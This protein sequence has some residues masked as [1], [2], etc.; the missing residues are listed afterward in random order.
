MK[1]KLKIKEKFQ[2]KMDNFM[3]KGGLSIF[4]SLLFLFCIMYFMMLTIRWSATYFVP[5]EVLSDINEQIWRVFLMMTDPGALENEDDSVLLQ[6]ILG[7]VTVFVGMVFFSSLVA[8]ITTE[9]N[10]RIAMLR[11]GKSQVLE[12]GHTIILGFNNR[13]LEIVKELTLAN[14]DE[15]GL[16]IVILAEK[17][18]EEM[19]DF[20]RDNVSDLKSS[21]IVTRNGNT[22]S[23]LALRKMGVKQCKS[24]IVLNQAKPSDP[25]K[26]QLIGDARVLKSILS[27]ATVVGEE[28]S[29]MVVCEFFSDKNRDLGLG[30]IPGKVIALQ[31][32]YIMAK[33]LVQTSR[34]PGLAFVYSDLVGYEG[35]E[36]YFIPVPPKALGRTYSEIIWHYK[37]TM[38]LGVMLENGQNLWNPPLEYVLKENDQLIVI[39]ESRSAIHYHDKPVV[40][41]REFEYSGSVVREKVD[42]ELIVGWSRKVQRLIDEYATY[43]IDG[44]RIDVIV[45]HATDSMNRQIQQIRKR[46]PYLSITLFEDDIHEKGVLEKYRPEN[47]DNVILVTEETDDDTE[48]MDAGTI[49]SLLELR[50]YFRDFEKRLNTKIHTQLITE[51]MD[52]RNA[53]LIY[54]SGVR[55]FFIPDQF[56][57]KILTQ[58]SQDYRINQAY[59]ELFSAEGNEIYIKPISLYFK[60]FPVKYRFAECIAAAQKRNE[61]CLGVR[62]SAHMFSH[63]RHFGI[64]LVPDKDQEFY[65]VRD[66]K[67]IVLA[68]NTT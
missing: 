51:V 22:S 45:S 46:Y 57:S 15:K 67:M 42:S 66:D 1:E 54:G 7:A 53:E 5:D 24:V 27:I 62:I 29:P 49:A 21:R 55:D 56:I 16:A 10:D 41:P 38:P 31:A 25:R 64:S 28:K 13:I 17:D 68:L 47:Y 14:E 12:R 11:K 35:D 9:F 39:A 34:N 37:R 4:I 63:E 40:T 61:V 32:D 50:N 44:S 30:I 3:A 58:V 19:D 59:N 26:K 60:R 8:F 48:E 52:S 6:K 65:F 20:F 2:Y 36:L 18:K 43:V 23:L 33:I